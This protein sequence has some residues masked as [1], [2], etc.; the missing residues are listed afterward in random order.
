[1]RV[2]TLDVSV[3][4]FSSEH[5]TT[6]RAAMFLASPARQHTQVVIRDVSWLSYSAHVQ[7]L[8]K[9]MAARHAQ[10]KSPYVFFA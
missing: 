4:A 1:M 10:Y 6:R 9:N 3:K 8:A 7:V 2:G 5:V